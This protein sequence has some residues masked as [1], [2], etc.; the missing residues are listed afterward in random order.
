MGS[1]H[2]KTHFKA[3][4]SIQTG[5]MG[6]LKVE[7]ELPENNPLVDAARQL[8]LRKIQENKKQPVYPVAAMPKNEEGE[9]FESQSALSKHEFDSA[10]VQEDRSSVAIDQF[11]TRSKMGPVSK[12]E[13][14]KND[15]YMLTEEELDQL[16]HLNFAAMNPQKTTLQVL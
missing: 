1:L 5:E 12:L 3:A 10:N 11:S 7:G 14:V 13:A 16:L 4:T 6:T 9:P 8:S 2:S 15:F